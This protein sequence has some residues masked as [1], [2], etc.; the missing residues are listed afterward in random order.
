MKVDDLLL[1]AEVHRQGSLSAGARVLD[2]P[3]ATLSRR[4]TALETSVGARLFVPGAKRLTL[5]ELGHE[6][7]ERALRHHDDI[8]E[9]RQ[10]LAS[11]DATPRGRLRVAMGSEFAMLVLSDALASFVQ[12][13]PEVE[14]DIDC[15]PRWV[16]LLN[17]PYDLTLRFGAVTEPELVARP[18]IT[19]HKGLFASPDYLARHGA[20]STPDDLAAHRF[21]VYTPMARKG[22]HRLH[23]G[24][25]T[26]S[27]T[28]QGPLH[29]NSMGLAVALTRAGSGIGTLPSAMARQEVATGALVP[30]LPEW[31]FEPTEVSLVTAS[32][33]LMPSK[34]RAFIDHLYEQVPAEMVEALREPSKRASAG[35]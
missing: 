18:F 33:R 10:W 32:R 22:Q 23:H 8:S 21:V 26:A 16:D 34:I 35:K 27:F 4:L 2:L 30:L 11:R 1:L 12:R 25:Q 13:Y 24:T 29:C 15:T 3:K 14:L 19:M 6:L 9:T 5:T 20:P 28:M 31:Q 7:A 17:E